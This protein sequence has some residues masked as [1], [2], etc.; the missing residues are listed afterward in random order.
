MQNSNC[1]QTGMT[2]MWKLQII[3]SSIEIGPACGLQC[4]YTHWT[5]KEHPP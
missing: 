4:E 2:G 5:A 1:H 3:S